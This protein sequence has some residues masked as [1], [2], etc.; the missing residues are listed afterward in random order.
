MKIWMTGATGF[1][2]SKVLKRLSA[3]YGIENIVTLSSGRLL[4]SMDSQS[5]SAGLGEGTAQEIADAQVLIHIGAF[6]PKSSESANDISG[7]NS[8]IIATENLLKICRNMPSLKKIVFTSTVDVYGEVQGRIS[9]NTPVCPQSMYG[10]SKLYCEKMIQVFSEE[11]TIDTT[12]LR[13]GH[14][15]GEGEEAYRKVIPVI[16]G[17]AVNQKEIR[18]YGDGEALRTFIYIDDVA[19][20]IVNSIKYKGE[21]IINVVGGES[22]SVNELAEMIVSLSESRSEILHVPVKTPNR[23]LVFDNRLLM[24][25]ILTRLTPLSEGLKHEIAY[26]RGNRQNTDIEERTR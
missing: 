9:E 2:G 13:V 10:W 3:E 11:R 12:I 24:D 19:E 25:T 14:V 15:F 1:I 6:I 7:S 8:N 22:I 21:E 17:N 4:G 23:N 16:I 26:F 18:I 5:G 20:G